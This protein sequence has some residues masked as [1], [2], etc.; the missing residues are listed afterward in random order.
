MVHGH[1]PL[2]LRTQFSSSSRKPVKEPFKTEP[3]EAPSP[4]PDRQLISVPPFDLA[5]VS[6]QGDMCL[7]KAHRST[8]LTHASC[9][10][11]KHYRSFLG[12]RRGVSGFE[13]SPV[14]ERRLP[15]HWQLL[16]YW[17]AGMATSVV[18]YV[19][20]RGELVVTTVDIEH[21][22]VPLE[23]DERCIDPPCMVRKGLYIS[24][25][26]AE[27]C[28]GL[29]KDRGITHV[30]QVG[31]ELRPSHPE[32]FVY[33]RLQVSDEEKEDLVG[34]FKEA[35]DFIDEARSSKGGQKVAKLQPDYA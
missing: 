8:L 4:E 7:R 27:H 3:L 31:S 17:L 33:K 28:K 14:S 19:Q 25:V 21:E 6:L 24:G 15:L 18:Q 32:H 35:F 10:S 23:D 2:S 11:A 5:S 9:K 22:P 34:S 16:Q 12:A 26:E 20:R 30:L 29:L 13:S 1:C